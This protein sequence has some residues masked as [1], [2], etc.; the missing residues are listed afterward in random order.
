MP[1]LLEMGF[2]EYIY[3]TNGRTAVAKHEKFQKSFY[4][5]SNTLTHKIVWLPPAIGQPK[6]CQCPI[7]LVAR[8]NKE[9]V[10]TRS[11]PLLD[12]TYFPSVANIR[13]HALYNR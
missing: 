13:I 12:D 4:S 1:L 9:A 8:R 7:Y 10:R 11:V 6:E 2:Q 3:C 5:I